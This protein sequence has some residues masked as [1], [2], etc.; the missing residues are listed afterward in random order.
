MINKGFQTTFGDEFIISLAADSFRKEIKNANGYIWRFWTGTYRYIS[1]C[2][3]NDAVSILH[4]PAEKSEGMIN[5]YNYILKHDS[6]PK[7]QK[8]HR[9]LHLVYPS[10]RTRVKWMVKTILNTT[11]KMSKSSGN[12]K[13]TEKTRN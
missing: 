8:A 9:M 1:T 10:M 5:M 7:I 11:R 13:K 3:K 2:Y 4:L 12:V 6:L